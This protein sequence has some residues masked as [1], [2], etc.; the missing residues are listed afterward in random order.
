MRT[1]T[2]RN[3]AIVLAIAVVVWLVP[4]GGDAASLVSQILSAA[5]IVLI[6]LFAMRGY[7]QFQG[8]LFGLGDA[9]RFVAYAAVGAAVLTMAAWN[10]LWVTSSGKL[11]L[12]A[13]LGACSYAL[14]LV[15][16]QYR[17]YS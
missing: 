12:F 15:W 1:E 10:R 14:Y 5:F 7:R 8:E 17:S 9:W 11:V 13:M 3:I 2:A 16:Q 4:G 6:V